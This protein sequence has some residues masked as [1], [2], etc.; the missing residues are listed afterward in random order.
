[1]EK[2][3]N[4]KEYCDAA[5]MGRFHL[6][7]ESLTHAAHILNQHPEPTIEELNTYAAWMGVNPDKVEEM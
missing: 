2:I 1:M 6:S 5:L 3:I 4:L 7:R